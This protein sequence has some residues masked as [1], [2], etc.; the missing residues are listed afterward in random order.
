MHQ[1]MPTFESQDIRRVILMKAPALGL[2]LV[3][4]AAT[5][6]YSAKAADKS[7]VVCYSFD[8]EDPKGV[9][10]LSQYKND[11]VIEGNAE[12]VEGKIG[13]AMQFDGTGKVEALH[14]DVL[15]L[16]GA[17][18]IA[19]WLKWDGSGSS[20]SPF[21]SKTISAQDDNYHT[22]VGSDRAWDYENQPNGQAHGKTPIPLDDKWI[23]LTVMHDGGKTISFYINGELDNTGELPTTEECKECPFR[24]GDDGKGNKGAGTIDELAIFNR[25]L[26]PDEIKKLMNEGAQAFV[27]VDCARKLTTTWGRIKIRY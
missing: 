22:W 17:H 10:D 15:S 12:Y 21:I 7:L 11:G 13:K 20:W 23:H 4:L 16:T 27:A 25:V 26:Q 24:V 1:R 2:L 14:S 5:F 8:D 9:K 18:T 6:C 19:Y 3:G